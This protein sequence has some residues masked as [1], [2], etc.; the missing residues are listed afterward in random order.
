MQGDRGG[1]YIQ[2]LQAHQGDI[3]HSCS[4]GLNW[5]T[6]LSHPSAPERDGHQ[7]LFKESSVFVNPQ[8]QA[9]HQYFK[10]ILLHTKNTLQVLI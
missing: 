4:C 9:T 3:Q 1:K 5:V 6:T 8:A 7:V 10:N 2:R